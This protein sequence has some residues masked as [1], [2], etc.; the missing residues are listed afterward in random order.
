VERQ[1]GSYQYGIGIEMTTGDHRAVTRCSILRSDDA[2]EFVIAGIAGLMGL[3]GNAGDKQQHNGR[4]GK[5]QQES[6][7]L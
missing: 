2:C 7:S 6:D 5:P 3:F 1:S 4:K